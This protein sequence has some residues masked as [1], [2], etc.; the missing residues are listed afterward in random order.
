MLT[1]ATI[2]LV[3]VLGITSLVAIASIEYFA[4]F[5]NLDDAEQFTLV[6]GEIPTGCLTQSIVKH[7]YYCAVYASMACDLI[8]SH[9][10]EANGNQS[11]CGNQYCWNCEGF[12]GQRDQLYE[13]FVSWDESDSCETFGG[14]GVCGH[15]YE[16]ACVW[17]P[18]NE[19]GVCEC[20]LP[21]H[22]TEAPCVRRD[23][24]DL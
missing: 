8:C 12:E 9:C 16:S 10:P 11:T 22:N 15:H 24:K 23:C 19:G 7:G 2:R 1:N 18:G 14:L 5:E 20:D 17:D 13:C 6:G 4:F 3:A 21:L